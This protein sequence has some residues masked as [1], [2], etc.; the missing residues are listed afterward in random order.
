MIF[1]I[2]IYIYIPPWSHSLEKKILVK[3]VAVFVTFN[4]TKWSTADATATECLSVFDHSV[5]LIA[6]GL[7]I[8][9]FYF[10]IYTGYNLK[11]TQGFK[12]AACVSRISPCPFLQLIQHIQGKRWSISPGNPWKVRWQIYSDMQ[13]FWRKKFHTMSRRSNFLSASFSNRANARISMLSRSEKQSQHLKKSFFINDWTIYVY[14]NSNKMIYTIKWNKL[15][16]MVCSRIIMNHKFQ[17]PQE[18]LNFEPLAWNI[19]T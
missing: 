4:P 7:T 1:P 19:V 17:W 11:M 15:T 6:S 18:G 10:W 16:S 14:I 9:R 2:Y 3:L 5:G 12:K 13:K 8:T